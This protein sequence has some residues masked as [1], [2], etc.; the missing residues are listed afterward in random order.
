MTSTRS[1]THYCKI[2][3]YS[4]ALSIVHVGVPISALAVEY[5]V[6]HLVFYEFKTFLHIF[7]SIKKLA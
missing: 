2:V 3:E 5:Q 7:L 4:T 6:H 1:H